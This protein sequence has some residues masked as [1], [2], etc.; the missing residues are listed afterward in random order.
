[1]FLK[2]LFW[3]I[4]LVVL[5]ALAGGVWLILHAWH[6]AREYAQLTDTH[7]LKDRI[8]KMGAD[9]V[10]GRAS[11]RLVVGILQRGAR[12]TRGFG[13]GHPPDAATPAAEMIFEIGSVTKVF[14]G[15]ALA[16]LEADGLVALDDCIGQ[17]LPKD[18]GLASA[19][20]PITLRQ[21][22][23]H[24]SGLPRLPDNLGAVCKDEAN[25]YVNYRAPDL[26]DCLHRVR[27]N[28]QPGK[29]AE[30]SNLGA[31]L[32]GHLLALKAGKSYE[33][34]VKEIICD[35]IGMSATSMILSPAHQQRLVPGHSP[36]GRPAS[37]WDFDV[38]APAGAFRSSV[39][40]MLKFLEANL[41]EPDGAQGSALNR[42]QEPHH[43]HWS[44]SNHGLGWQIENDVYT[45]LII[46]WHN[47]GTGGYVSFI[48]LVKSHQVAVVLLSNY[49]DAC[50][51]DDAID[52]MGFRIL[53]YASKISL[54]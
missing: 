45:G 36:E 2:L 5:V 16:K 1:M 53:K 18:V 52:Q 44:G 15:I 20:E 8:E 26:Y 7:D 51:G 29:G 35:P 32:L 38:L 19:A 33:A 11:A 12:Y 46:H 43:S 21:L 17:H 9:Y 27:L 22:A 42:A 41:K 23:T 31:G 4:L 10:A 49:G 48:G 28:R 24:T 40:D 50:A 3:G 37:N 39:A 30:Y 47:G 14:T 34:L 25:P 13:A 6:Q 54:G